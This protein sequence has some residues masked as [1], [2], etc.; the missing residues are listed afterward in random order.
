M[1]IVLYHWYKWCFCFTWKCTKGISTNEGIWTHI[2]KEWKKFYRMGSQCLST[3]SRRDHTIFP[4]VLVL[5]IKI[6]SLM[7][8]WFFFKNSTHCSLV[9]VNFFFLRNRQPKFFLMQCTLVDDNHAPSELFW[10]LSPQLSELFSI[11]NGLQIHRWTLDV[12][13]LGGRPI[14]K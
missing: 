14:R 11:L 8:I 4:H 10:A 12:A 3:H 6:V 1:V 9:F 2:Q 7:L 5:I 13:H